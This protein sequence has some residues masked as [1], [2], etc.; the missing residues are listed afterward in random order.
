MGRPA[1]TVRLHG[2]TIATVYGE[3][4]F[5]AVAADTFRAWPTMTTASRLRALGVPAHI[6]KGQ[7]ML[8]GVPV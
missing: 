2:N 4:G 7:A 6:V 1:V 5:V 3:T 8:E